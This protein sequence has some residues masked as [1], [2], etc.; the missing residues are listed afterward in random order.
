M[1]LFIL[2]CR[3]TETPSETVIEVRPDDNDHDVSI[4]DTS[5]ML[6]DIDEDGYW[7]DVD[8]DDWNPN[9]HPDAEEIWNQED[10]DCDGYVDIDGQH[11]GWLHLQATGIFEGQA[12]HF[13]QECTGVIHRENGTVEMNLLCEID[14]TQEKASLLLGGVLSVFA[15]ENFV[16]EESAVSQAEFASVDGEMEW[17]AFGETS[18]QWSSWDSDKGNQI[19]V[20]AILDAIYLDIQI[21][22]NLDRE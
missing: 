11:R 6:E 7:S 15:K 8:C 16:F 9:I 10:D 12:Y 14:Q 1:W 19:Q 2:A 5:N 20:N 18:W 21:S 4:E 13:T 22:G 3:T 17:H